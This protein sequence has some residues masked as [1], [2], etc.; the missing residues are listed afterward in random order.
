MKVII[1][2]GM[3]VI[4]IPVMLWA[5]NKAVA[6]NDSYNWI[7]VI[8]LVIVVIGIITLIAR[9]KHWMNG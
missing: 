4:G 2:I 9:L 6:G 7:W 8:A 5:L 1:G 3:A